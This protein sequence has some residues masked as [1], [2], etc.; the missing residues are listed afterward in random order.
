[1]STWLY[2]HQPNMK[3]SKSFISHGM[4][5]TNAP[6]CIAIGEY[7][8]CE[9]RLIEDIVQPGGIRI[10][11]NDNMLA[12]FMKETKGMETYII[13]CLLLSKLEANYSFQIKAK[14][15]YTIEYL[16][17][18]NDNYLSYFKAQ[19]DKIKQSP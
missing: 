11:P 17:K 3:G 6:I 15:L 7:R 1:M 8:E 16:I 14:A 4:N 19:V 10:K 2:R 5:W 12:E 18:K 9:K 13:G